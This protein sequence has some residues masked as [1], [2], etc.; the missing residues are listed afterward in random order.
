MPSAVLLPVFLAVTIA[1]G[2]LFSFV[3][4]GER[5]LFAVVPF[6][7]IIGINGYNFFVNLSAYA[8]PI[9]IAPQV[10][11]AVFAAA[12]VLLFWLVRR[13]GIPLT[14]DGSG[15]TPRQVKILFGIAVAV[16][17]L[18]G[19]F[20]LRSLGFDDLSVGHLSLVSTILEGNFPVMDPAAP[21][22][23]VEYHYGSDLLTTSLAKAATVPPWLG[24]DIQV[25]LFSGAA[26]LMAFVIA[27]DLSGRWRAA[28]IASLLMLLGAGLTWL[29]FTEGVMPFWQKFVVGAE[30]EAPWKFL[31]AMTGPRINTSILVRMFNHNA[32][33]GFPVML[34]AITLF[35]RMTNLTGR[36]L[37]AYAVT[38][39]VALGYLALN[40][41]TNFVIL[42][43]A[44]A[45]ALLVLLFGRRSVLPIADRKGFVVASFAVLLIGSALALFQGGI[46]S[47]LF[48]G[49]GRSSFVFA[50]N[51]LTL[52]F[53]VSPWSSPDPVRFF[54]WTMLEEFGLVLL[55][56]VPAIA[57]YRRNAKVLF[58]ALM[59]VT[60]FIAPFLVL[61]ETRPHEMK[62][63][64]GISTPF[65]FFVGGLYLDELLTRFADRAWR[66]RLLWLTVLLGISWSL[67]Y[68]AVYIVTPYGYI[69]KLDRP[70][71]ER[72]PV[73]AVIDERAYAWIRVNTTIRD[74]FFPFSNNFIRDTGRFTPGY[75]GPGWSPYPEVLA[76]YDRFVASCVPAALG[77]L[78]V[79]HLYISPSF[80]LGA[81]TTACLRSLGAVRVYHEEAGGDFRSIYRPPA[82]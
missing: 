13:K 49:S 1:F 15:F 24:Y 65:M 4:L 38:A 41:E 63:L 70:L 54:S 7:V 58:L 20:A 6:A 26:F 47:T 80:P 16:T 77:E 62:R 68:L 72:P 75:F 23:P 32:M 37:L 17:V 50:R 51:F 36:K 18:A 19:A 11:L 35:F 8:I 22:H 44:I 12:D 59:A 73:P 10:V 79:T 34:L 48:S 71:I 9:A 67:Y 43:A 39:G 52:D 46:L 40:L 5:R 33:I 30:V 3:A 69:G 2:Y 82:L 55:L 81:K 25:L 57:A 27:F 31:A 78:K 29:R 28:I 64:F 76:A 42:S 61:Y 53:T 56:F 45:A 21:D 14:P 74:R 66:V 60:A